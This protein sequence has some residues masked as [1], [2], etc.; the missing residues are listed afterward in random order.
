[1]P[2]V[3]EATPTDRE[4]RAL[5]LVTRPGGS[6]R[7]AAAVMGVSES[8]VRGLLWTLYRKLGVSSSGQAVRAMRD[9][10]P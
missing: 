8:R 6:A 5:D 3:E 2:P 9:R 1:V 7:A 10:S 4:L